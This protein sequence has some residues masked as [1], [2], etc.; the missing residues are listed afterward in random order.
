MF[1]FHEFLLSFNDEFFSTVPN[2]GEAN[3]AG[4]LIWNRFRDLQ[5]FNSL[6]IFPEKT[7]LHTYAPQYGGTWSVSSTYRGNQYNFR[8][9][10]GIDYMEQ[11]RNL[12]NDNGVVMDS[13]DT[14]T[15]Y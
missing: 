5:L 9:A 14:R 15:F 10:S 4:G 3:V 13:K 7:Y 12:L 6:D 11:P 8:N 1:E 2:L